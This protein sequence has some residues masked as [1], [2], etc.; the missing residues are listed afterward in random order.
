MSARSA[1]C[2]FKAGGIERRLGGVETRAAHVHGDAAVLGEAWRDHAGQGLHADGVPVGEALVAHVAGEAARA[3]AALLDLA[4]VGV[5]D[6]VFEVDAVGWRRTH[7]E[8]LVGA[9]PEVAVGEIA[10]LRGREAQ[11]PLR[12]VEHDEIVA[13]TLHFGEADLHPQDYRCPAGMVWPLA[14]RGRPGAR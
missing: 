13:G 3:V 6:D 2:G 1:D 5:V 8:D 10:V 4:A 12:F 11:A 7:G 14:G 9:D